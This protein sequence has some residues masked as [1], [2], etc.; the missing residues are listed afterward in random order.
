MM[1]MIFVIAILGILAAVAIPKLTA[2]RDDAITAKTAQNIMIGASEIASY[3]IANGNTTTDLSIMSNGVS[4]LVD[5]GDAV[6]DTSNGQATIEV[7]TISDCVIVKVDVGIDDENLSI[8]FGN[9]GADKKCL[10]LQNAIDAQQYPM[11][12]R[13]TLVVQ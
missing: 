6:L 13:G 2:T 7:G 8:S 3:A 10:N 4:V 11:Q 12:L 1:E 5:D 9:A